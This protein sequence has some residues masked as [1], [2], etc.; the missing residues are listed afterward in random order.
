MRWIH[1]KDES[2]VRFVRRSVL[3]Y[4]DPLAPQAKQWGSTRPAAQ[5]PQEPPWSPPA[6]TDPPPMHQVRVAAMAEGQEVVV[7]VRS[8]MGAE[9]DVVHDQIRPVPAAGCL[10]TILV[11]AED[12]CPDGASI[13]VREAPLVGHGSEEGDEAGPDGEGVALLLADLS[14][15]EAQVRGQVSW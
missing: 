2:A 6:H 7:T 5:Q 14:E 8:P 12:R 11:P 1:E 3:A 15:G 10:A 4:N 9:L 13:R